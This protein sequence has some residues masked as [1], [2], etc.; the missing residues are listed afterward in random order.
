MQAC[1]S[2]SKDSEKRKHA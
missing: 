1:T 2:I